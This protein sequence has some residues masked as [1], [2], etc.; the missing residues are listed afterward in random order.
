MERVEIASEDEARRTVL[1]LR[2][3]GALERRGHVYAGT[4]PHDVKVKR[5]ARGKVAKASRKQ[6]RGN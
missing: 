2:F 5:R 1:G 6:N 4:V 3:L